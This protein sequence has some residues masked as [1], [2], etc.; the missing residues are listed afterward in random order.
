MDELTFQ[1]DGKPI[2][3]RLGDSITAALSAAGEQT[4][5]SRRS[6]RPR[7]A[8]CGMGVCHDCLVTV[9]GERG[10]R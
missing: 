3:A 8:F 6:G 5:G 4:L 2:S 9:D 7:G 10:Q 1:L